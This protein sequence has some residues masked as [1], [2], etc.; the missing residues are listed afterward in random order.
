[1]VACWSEVA[2]A[3]STC[4]AASAVAPRLLHGAIVE[5]RE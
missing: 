3:P 2:A 5:A 1:M 4:G